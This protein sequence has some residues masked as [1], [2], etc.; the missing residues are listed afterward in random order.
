MEIIEDKDNFLLNRREVKVLVESKTNPTYKESKE[1]LVKQFDS[2]GD[3]IVVKKIKG[4]FGMN[5]F[6]ISGFIYKNKEDMQKFEESTDE[7]KNDKEDSD[8]ESDGA[9]EESKSEEDGK[10]N[11]VAEDK[12][13]EK[14]DE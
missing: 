1:I 12:Q 2:E 13:E 14:K 4:K 10:E 7:G 3:K 11:Q 8:A 6:L 5:T 9:K